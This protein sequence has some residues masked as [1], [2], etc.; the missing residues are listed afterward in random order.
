MIVADSRFVS[1]TS[2]TLRLASIAVAP[3]FSV[4][5]SVP[6]ASEIVGTSLS[7]VTLTVDVTDE[8]LPSPSLRTQVIVRAL[9]LGFSE[10]LL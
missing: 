6:A 10:V 5:E 7:A 2:P 4:K 8:L 1:S 9:V 3:P